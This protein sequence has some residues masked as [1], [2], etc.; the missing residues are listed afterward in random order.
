MQLDMECHGLTTISQAQSRAI[1]CMLPAV[2]F[3][4][5]GIKDDIPVFEPGNQLLAIATSDVASAT[6]NAFANEN[7]ILLFVR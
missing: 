2:S 1:C 4:R 7:F 3:E 5:R 6:R